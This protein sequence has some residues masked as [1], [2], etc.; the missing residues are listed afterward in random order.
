MHE[1]EFGIQNILYAGNKNASNAL[2]K[3]EIEIEILILVQLGTRI[4]WFLW[5]ILRRFLCRTRFLSVFS[6]LSCS[7]ENISVISAQWPRW[8]QIHIARKFIIAS[9]FGRAFFLIFCFLFINFWNEIHTKISSDK[10]KPV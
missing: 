10:S 9:I 2:S 7:F 4:Y 8:H 1:H 3:F 6:G 5:G